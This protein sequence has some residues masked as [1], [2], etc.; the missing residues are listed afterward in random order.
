MVLGGS[1]SEEV[2]MPKTPRRLGTGH[3]NVILEDDFAKAPG[4]GKW[5]FRVETHYDIKTAEEFD[6][7]KG[8]LGTKDHRPL[9]NHLKD[10][11][12]QHDKKKYAMRMFSAAL[13]LLY[14]RSTSKQ[15]KRARARRRR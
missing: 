5:V 8:W 10:Q 14:P 12:P 1:P 9:F 6:L 7:F 15:K 4:P 3:P 11:V 2:A 13:E